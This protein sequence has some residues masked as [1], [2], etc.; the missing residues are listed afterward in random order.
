MRIVAGDFRGRP[1]A[2]PKTSGTRP[3]SDR[4]RETVFNIIS[5]AEWAPPLAGARVIDLFAGS[6][7]LGLEA[8]SRGAD[9]ALFVEMG[10]AARAAILENINVFGISEKTQFQRRD[11]MRLGPISEDLERQFDIAFIDPPYFK[12][13]VPRSLAGLKTGGWLQPEALCVVETG[14]DEALELPGWTVRDTRRSGAAK[15]WFLSQA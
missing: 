13:L 10:L 3:T 5:H 11:V 15:F 1:I 14:A 9:F 12:Q 4:A 7:A 2:A 6:G 8:I